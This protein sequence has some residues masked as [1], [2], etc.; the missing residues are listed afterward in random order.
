MGTRDHITV[1]CCVNTAGEH[2]SPMIID[3]KGYQGL[4]HAVGQKMLYAKWPNGYMDTEL[5]HLWFT[6]ITKERPLLLI[7]DGHSSHISPELIDEAKKNRLKSCAC[8]LI[9]RMFCNPSTVLYGPLKKDG[10]QQLL[11]QDM[12]KIQLLNYNDFAGISNHL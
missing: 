7:Q 11:S 12:P 10:F 8:H 3:E 5:H 6:K 4:T 1:H 2:F 9:Q